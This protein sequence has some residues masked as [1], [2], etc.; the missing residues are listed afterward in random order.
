M[1][2]PRAGW[3]VAGILALTAAVVL[4]LTP[5]TAHGVDCGPPFAQRAFDTTEGTDGKLV[6]PSTCNSPA[7]KRKLYI[8]VLGILGAT[9][10]TSALAHAAWTDRPLHRLGT[11]P[12]RPDAPPTPPLP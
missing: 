2:T 12:T 10:T 5:V 3:L 11:P 7:D 4:T 1:S 6:G 9:A 8:A